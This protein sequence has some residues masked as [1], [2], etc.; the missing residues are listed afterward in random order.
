MKKFCKPEIKTMK[1]LLLPS[2]KSAIP[3]NKP[4]KEL[5]DD[6]KLITDKNELVD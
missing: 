2:N 1:K 4:V 6:L 3:Q 5:A